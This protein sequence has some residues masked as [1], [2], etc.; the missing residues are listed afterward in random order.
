MAAKAKAVPQLQVQM[1]DDQQEKLLAVADALETSLESCWTITREIL[2]A[3]YPQVADA[4]LSRAVQ[5]LLLIDAFLS[6][7]PP[8][9]NSARTFKQYAGMIGS[10][11]VCGIKVPGAA[12]DATALA[13]QANADLKIGRKRT[14]NPAKKGEKAAKL[15]G[16]N[17][18]DAVI[19]VLKNG[20][21]GAKLIAGLRKHNWHIMPRGQ[22]E[23]MESDLKH[24]NKKL[25]DLPKGRANGRPI[26]GLV[27]APAPAEAQ[28]LAA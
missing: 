27:P 12:S 23:K 28:R 1:S 19:A 18:L 2:L 6:E 11:V 24:A 9:S 3:M 16:D 17:V 25:A 14:P 20:K 22:Y 10:L 8:V 4:N 13:K 5:R 21:G 7:L 26:S 15:A